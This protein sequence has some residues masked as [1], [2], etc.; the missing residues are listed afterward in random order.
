MVGRKIDRP[1]PRCDSTREKN[2]FDQ[3]RRMGRKAG[4]KSPPREVLRNRR[5]L[6]RFLGTFVRTQKYLA[7]RR[8]TPCQT[9]IQTTGKFGRGKPLPYGAPRSAAVTETLPLIRPSVRT[10]AP[11]PRGRLKEEMP[12][13]TTKKSGGVGREKHGTTT[14]KVRQHA[15]EKCVRPGPPDGKKSRQQATTQG[16]P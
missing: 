1:P 8:N 7:R 9:I 12:P 15:G 16:S 2:V 14:T 11:S 5:F 4:S 3:D 13:Q 10:G 6:S